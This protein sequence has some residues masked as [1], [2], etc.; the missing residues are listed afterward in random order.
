MSLENTGTEKGTMNK[1]HVPKGIVFWLAFGIDIYKGVWY[2]AISNPGYTYVSFTSILCGK[3]WGQ[4]PLLFIFGRED[5]GII[6]MGCDR[7]LVFVSQERGLVKMTFIK[8]FLKNILMGNYWVLLKKCPT[9][10]DVGFGSRYNACNPKL[11]FIYLVLAVRIETF[12][13]DGPGTIFLPHTLTL[14][15]WYETSRRVAFI[16]ILY[17]QWPL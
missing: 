6:G 10:S 7:V 5:V 9:G 4:R 16:G 1:F 12:F 2:L 11:Y 14:P 17:P 3:V 13:I 8:G 15:L